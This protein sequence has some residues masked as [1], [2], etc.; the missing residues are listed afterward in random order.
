[1]F[2]SA[3]CQEPQFQQD[4]SSSFYCSLSGNLIMKRSECRLTHEAMEIEA[5][6][7][8]AREQACE[9]YSVTTTSIRAT[10]IDQSVDS[11]KMPGQDQMSSK[12]PV[13]PS[14]DSSRYFDNFMPNFNRLNPDEKIQAIYYF[15]LMV[16]RDSQSAS[17]TLNKKERR[18]W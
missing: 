4:S 15:R 8:Y 5:G 11:P 6:P 18:R 13:G 17:P 16:E 1:M 12:T 10:I 9:R 14:P 3:T 2:L 7:R